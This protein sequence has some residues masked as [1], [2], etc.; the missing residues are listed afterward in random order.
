MHQHIPDVPTS[1]LQC[2]LSLPSSYNSDAIIDTRFEP[3]QSTIFESLIAVSVSTFNAATTHPQRHTTGADRRSA[4]C[5]SDIACSG[6]IYIPIAYSG[7]VHV[8]LYTTSHTIRVSAPPHVPYHQ[9]YCSI[10]TS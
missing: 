4:A 7:S 1:M 9:R 3:N 2:Q 10:I 8:H 6:D 5:L